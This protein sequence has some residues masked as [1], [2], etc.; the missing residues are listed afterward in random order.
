[1]ASIAD[2]FVNVAVKG[3]EGLIKSFGSIKDGLTDVSSK[4]L[5]VKA[6]ILGIV[7]GIEEL[8]RVSGERGIKLRIFENISGLGTKGTQDLQQW[9]RAL[10]KLGVPLEETEGA[11]VK[12][13][14]R[15]A[16]IPAG[17]LS[18]EFVTLFQLPGFDTNKLRDKATGAFDP[19]YILQQL[20]KNI[21][22][23]PA[24]ELNRIFAF[25]Q[26]IV[27]ENILAQLNNPRFDELFGQK[28]S[29]GKGPGEIS[30]LE[31]MGIRFNTFVLRL[32]DIRD[33][34]AEIFGPT[35]IHWADYAA[36]KLDHFLTMINKAIDKKG[37]L[38]NYVKYVFD[39]IKIKLKE[40]FDTIGDYFAKKFAKNLTAA[41]KD[42]LPS[43]F[44]SL[45]PSLISPFTGTNEPASPIGKSLE[46]VAVPQYKP[47]DK[48][49][50]QD[51]KT[52]NI[53]IDIHAAN[54]PE[55]ISDALQGQLNR[56]VYGSQAANGV[57]N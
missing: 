46:H 12:L 28:S 39:L 49:V 26:P 51:H 48:P 30:K 47:L 20:H 19:F 42:E 7:A 2:L 35:L 8:V 25:L 15:L 36:N 22:K 17:E 11:L 38:E 18:R 34:F 37:G 1:M 56:Y 33:H 44:K 41:L 5:A 40:A 55:A 52:N 57:T 9:E 10:Y 29:R 3:S 6:T 21:K 14:Q 4:G 31:G 27:G 23:I 45:I 54:D 43:L 24:G 32:M 13:Q 53:K 16:T 50:R